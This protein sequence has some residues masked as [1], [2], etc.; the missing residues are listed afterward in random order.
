MWN[1]PPRLQIWLPELTTD[2]TN[3]IGLPAGDGALE[4]R[5]INMEG[6][7]G[8][9]AKA[10]GLQEKDIVIAVAGQPIRMNSKQFS[11]WLK[12]NYKV[13]QKLP[14]TILRNGQRREISL[15]LVE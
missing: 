7:G 1:A 8:R 5:W 11:A 4:V 3:A 13:G 2:Q 15:L 12:L 6:P 14:L 9:Q 10:D